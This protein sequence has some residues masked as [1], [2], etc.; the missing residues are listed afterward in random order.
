MRL[1]KAFS[2][3]SLEDLPAPDKIR[4]GT[5]DR[6]V[7]DGNAWWVVDYKTSRPLGGETVESFLERESN[8]YRPQLH[9]Y[10]EMVANYF[11]VDLSSVRTFLYFTTLQRKIEVKS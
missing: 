9:A 3:W 2:K 8:L 11:K 4:T 7:F 10:G 6:I 1:W 5:L